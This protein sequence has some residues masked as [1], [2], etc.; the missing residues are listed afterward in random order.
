MSFCVNSLLK[1]IPD[2]SLNCW[3]STPSMT[4]F[5]DQKLRVKHAHK[6]NPKFNYQIDVN[7]RI[8]DEQ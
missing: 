7:V 1:F 8:F 4:L 2:G 5:R 6:T 3:M